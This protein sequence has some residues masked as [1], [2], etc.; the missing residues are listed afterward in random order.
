MEEVGKSFSIFSG[1]RW[2]IPRVDLSATPSIKGDDYD[3]GANAGTRS[4]IPRRFR[5][6]VDR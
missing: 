1:Q 6:L 2:A 5:K 4:G 3:D